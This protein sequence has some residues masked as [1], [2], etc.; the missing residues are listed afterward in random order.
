MTEEDNR[1]PRKSDE[2]IDDFIN[3][4]EGSLDDLFGDADKKSASP[5]ELSSPEDSA[6]TAD[7]SIETNGLPLEQGLSSPEQEKSTSE[8]LPQMPHDTEIE[9]EERTVTPTE[10]HEIILL[11]E[12]V[13]EPVSEGQTESGT[14]LKPAVVET[15][16]SLP[17][18]FQ[19]NS[20]AKHRVMDRPQ[21]KPAI[22]LSTP[23]SDKKESP[24]ETAVQT[25]KPVP[26][27]ASLS[28]KKQVVDLDTNTSGPFHI[29]LIAGAAV[30]LAVLTLTYY[31]LAPPKTPDFVSP[32][33]KPAESK[34]SA[35]PM[36]G[37]KKPAA[38]EKEAQLVDENIKPPDEK[39][40]PASPAKST[41]IPEKKSPAADALTKSPSEQTAMQKSVPEVSTKSFPTI[42]RESLL[43]PYSIHA[44]SFRSR[45]TADKEVAVLRQKNLQAFWVQVD[46]GKIGV[47]YRIFVGCFQTS[48]AAQKAIHKAG[49]KNATPKKTQ[50]AVFIDSF[51]TTKALSQRERELEYNGFS[52]YAIKEDA[53]NYRL[54]VGAY[55][56]RESALAL[57]EQLLAKGITAKVVAR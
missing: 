43:Y 41:S 48:D 54:Y 18:G 36:V 38:V 16:G 44:G 26:E 32:P 45:N 31:F 2:I 3:E 34:L 33:S 46:L 24:A 42:Q 23:S 7:E 39:P 55:V 6:A 1:D 40:L 19:P 12:L 51:N 37:S 53:A 4:L 5:E 14:V 35:T 30:I 29:K 8:Q 47:W 17:I 21:P 15:N 52:P 49:L 56:N 10:E 50:Y 27:R 9:S 20:T 28:E 57:Y 11:E 22:I 25:E 13:A